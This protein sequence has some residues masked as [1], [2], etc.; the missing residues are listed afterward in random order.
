MAC[1]GVSLTNKYRQTCIHPSWWLWG[2]LSHTLTLVKWLLG[3]GIMP[4]LL[5]WT[6][7]NALARTTT[8]TSHCVLISNGF[9]KGWYQSL[10]TKALSWLWLERWL[11]GLRSTWLWYSTLTRVSSFS[12]ASL[13]W[14]NILSRLLGRRKPHMLPYAK[15]SLTGYSRNVMTTPSSL[16]LLTFR[17]C[18]WKPSLAC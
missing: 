2:P 15:K 6:W 18:T 4:Y 13:T 17:K 5:L 12:R 11:T 7:P 16:L 8:A 14:S 1:L 9:R 10:V 3:R